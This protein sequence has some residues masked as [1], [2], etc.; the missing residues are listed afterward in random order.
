MTLIETIRAEANAVASE[1]IEARRRE[2]ETKRWR[3]ELG[4]GTR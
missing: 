2:D 4:Q 1:Q 3:R